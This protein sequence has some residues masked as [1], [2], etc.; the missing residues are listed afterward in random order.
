MDLLN[1][2]FWSTE[3]CAPFT[4]EYNGQKY[5]GYWSL[6]AAIRRGLPK[7]FSLIAKTP[8]AL[9]EGFKV[10]DCDFWLDTSDETWHHIFRSSAP[11]SQRCPLLDERIN[12]I[13]EAGRVLNEV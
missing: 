11:E 5:T 13:R 7:S 9:A 3:A 12:V 6:I 1:F 8:L 4:V 10:L 2:S